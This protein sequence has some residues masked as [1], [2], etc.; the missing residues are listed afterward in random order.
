MKL[1]KLG[2]IREIGEHQGTP[3]NTREHDGNVRTLEKIGEIWEIREHWG[4]V[5]KLGKNRE[6]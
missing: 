3:G 1:G 6:H 2:N 5:R 4:N